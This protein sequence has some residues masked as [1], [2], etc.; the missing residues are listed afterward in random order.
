M[1][2][3]LLLLNYFF[4]EEARRGSN[5]IVSYYLDARRFLGILK[6]AGKEKLSQTASSGKR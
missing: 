6:L 5:R 3:A 4:R 2:R 1:I